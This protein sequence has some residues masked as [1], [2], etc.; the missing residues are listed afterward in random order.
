LIDALEVKSSAPNRTFTDYF[1]RVFEQCRRDTGLPSKEEIKVSRDDQRSYMNALNNALND[2]RTHLTY[3]FIDMDDKLKITMDEVKLNVAELFLN[4]GKLAGLLAGKPPQE[5]FHIMAA[6]HLSLHSR[7]QKNFEIFD[8]YELALRGFFQSRLRQN[9][10]RMIPDKS[11]VQLLPDR[12]TPEGVLEQLRLIQ[13]ETVTEIEKKLMLFVDEP[14]QAAFAVVHEF[15]DQVFYSKNVKDHWR[16][17]YHPR[18]AQ[19][20]KHEFEQSAKSEVFQREWQETAKRAYA[21]V[22]GSPSGHIK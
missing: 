22:N 10:T 21:V 12:L 8:S 5:L 13:A 18:K 20:W 2:M 4:R 15:I 19:I 6:D 17:F 11:N 9:L 7:L 3:H 16:G 1:R 14:S